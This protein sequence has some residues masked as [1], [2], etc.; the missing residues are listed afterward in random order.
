MAILDN[1]IFGTVRGKIGDLIFKLHNGKTII[2]QMPAKRKASVDI[3]AVNRRKRFALVNKL[4][5]QINKTQ[6]LKPFWYK[7]AGKKMTVANAI[8]KAN[9]DRV[10]HNRIVGI[11]YLTPESFGYDPSSLIVN[12]KD[13]VITVEYDEKRFPFI[14]NYN[15]DTHI[16]LHSII[17]AES[18]KYTHDP[19]E[20]F[21]SI[22]SAL[23]QVIKDGVIV[24]KL[25]LDSCQENI[26]NSY[27][28]HT[29]FS[30]LVSYK[31]LTIPVRYLSTFSEPFSL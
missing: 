23:E 24:F 17:Y 8:T 29:M 31:S 9:Y 6:D 5:Q 15:E 14:K 4:S 16:R 18:P 3:S 30:A 22:S 19:N 1:P 12:H 10:S 26:I 7:I 20:N 21:I 2:C 25:T 11:P 27:S 28:K 13:S